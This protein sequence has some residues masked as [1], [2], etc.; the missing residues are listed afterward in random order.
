MPTIEMVGRGAVTTWAFIWEEG[1]FQGIF[2]H[3]YA[4]PADMVMD[5]NLKGRAIALRRDFFRNGESV[6]ADKNRVFL[7]G[8][9]RTHS[10]LLSGSSDDFIKTDEEV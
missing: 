6:A 8:R 10:S 5:F 4:A 9:I 1:K 2:S 7:G 3:C